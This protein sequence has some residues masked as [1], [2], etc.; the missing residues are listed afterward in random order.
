MRQSTQAM[1]HSCIRQ[2]EQSIAHVQPT[3][4]QIVQQETRLSMEGVRQRNSH[5]Q[6]GKSTLKAS[7]IICSNDFKKN[8]FV[9]QQILEVESAKSSNNNKLPT[10]SRPPPQVQCDPK[11]TSKT[12]KT[13]KGK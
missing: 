5:L 1:K 3:M 8:A 9:E 4:S 2:P 10:N 11:R 13:K 12:E 7:T 6:E